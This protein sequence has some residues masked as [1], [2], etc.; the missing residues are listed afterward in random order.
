VLLI[1]FVITTPLLDKGMELNLPKATSG[2]TKQPDKKDIRTVEIDPKG[3]YWLN[4]S[5]IRLESLVAQLAQD[6][7]YNPD[8]VI[9]VRADENSK[10]KDFVAL[11]DGCQQSGISR[12][13]IRT[14]PPKR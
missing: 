1:I 6:Y 13:S 7:K 14:A 8:L 3:I 10:M 11:T 12:F 9:Y 4:A 5:A 2:S